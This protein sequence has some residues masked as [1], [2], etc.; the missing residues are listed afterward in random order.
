MNRP[1][2]H[3]PIRVSRT[4]SAAEEESLASPEGVGLA[5]KYP[6]WGPERL[7]AELDRLAGGR[8]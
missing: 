6:M 2:P 4:L 7:L 1:Q 3:H 8:S 5:E